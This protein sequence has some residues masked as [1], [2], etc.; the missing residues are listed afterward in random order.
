MRD[1]I[2]VKNYDGQ[3]ESL[4]SYCLRLSKKNNSIM[5]KLEKYLDMKLLDDDSLVEIRDTL[6]TVSADISKLKDII[7]ISGDSHEGL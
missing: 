6:L 2:Y 7:V 3:V 1:N 5:Y 4:S